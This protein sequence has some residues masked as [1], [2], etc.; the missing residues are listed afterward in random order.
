M[1]TNISSSLGEIPPSGPN[2]ID[3]L[4][5]NESKKIERW[6]RIAKEASEQS[7]RLVIP[8]VNNIISIKEIET[9][10]GVNILCSLDKNNVKEIKNVLNEETLCDKISIV[11]GPEG[12]TLLPKRL[13]MNLLSLK[14]L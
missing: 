10:K 1:L 14:G 2:T 12:G 13:E 5:H 11:F 6:S 4:S 8:K 3:I 7:R 9:V